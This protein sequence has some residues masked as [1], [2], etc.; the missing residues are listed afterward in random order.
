MSLHNPISHSHHL[1]HDTKISRSKPFLRAAIVLQLTI[2]AGH[3]LPG[4]MTET[5]VTVMI[6]TETATETAT[7]IVT[8]MVVP[9]SD[10]IVCQAESGLMNRSMTEDDLQTVIAIN[11]V[12]RP[13]ARPFL[14]FLDTD[15]SLF[16]HLAYT[17]NS[18]V[19]PDRTWCGASFRHTCWFRNENAIPRL[20]SRRL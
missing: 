6:A 9:I 15:K 18:F 12:K 1:L 17:A 14:P 8:G 5:A 7:E 3:A 10:V 20:G 19:Q 13:W 2:R 4:D 11:T 16:Q